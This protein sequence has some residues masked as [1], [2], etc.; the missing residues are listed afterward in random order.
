M[1][2][3]SRH[4]HMEQGCTPFWNMGVVA[5]SVA[6][7]VLGRCSVMVAPTN[8]RLKFIYL[9]CTLVRFSALDD[10]NC[11]VYFPRFIIAEAY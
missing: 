11:I 4:G 6:L 9:A 5:C 1:S 7:Q 3:A 10:T 2:L 8:R